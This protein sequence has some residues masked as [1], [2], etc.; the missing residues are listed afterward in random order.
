MEFK[1]KGYEVSV[2]KIYGLFR[3][4]AY[5]DEHPT[6]ADREGGDLRTYTNAKKTIKRWINEYLRDP[7]AFRKRYPELV[8]D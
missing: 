8:R 1:Y 7:N 4:Y 5:S 2:D 6:L 3:W